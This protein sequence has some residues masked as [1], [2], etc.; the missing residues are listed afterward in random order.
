[1]NRKDLDAVCRAVKSLHGDMTQNFIARVAA[2][3][4]MEIEPG[5]ANFDRRKFMERC[6][7]PLDAEGKLK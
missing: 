6:G 2:K 4:A 7:C 1:M 5:N 3:L